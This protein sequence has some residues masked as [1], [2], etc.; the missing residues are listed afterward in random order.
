MKNS[1]ENDNDKDMNQNESHPNRKGIRFAPDP[2]TVAWIDLNMS[3]TDRPFTP[4]IAALVTEESYRG[5]GLIVVSC[6]NI[7]VGDQFR[8]KIG[9]GAETVA[10][11]RWRTELDPGVARIGI[12]FLR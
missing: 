11:V 3:I 5:A 8:I 2:G 6:G 12:M 4:E 1:D 9:H 10:E 7:K